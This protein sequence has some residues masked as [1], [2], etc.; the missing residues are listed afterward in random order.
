MHAGNKLKTKIIKIEISWDQADQAAR[1]KSVRTGT[2]A[3]LA[4]INMGDR[5]SDDATYGKTRQN[6][7]NPPQGYQQQVLS[8]GPIRICH[9]RAWPKYTE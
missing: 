9:A 4:Y 8:C 7:S 2:P 3:E 5:S 6:N 1:L